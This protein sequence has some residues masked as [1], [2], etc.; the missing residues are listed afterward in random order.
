MMNR[1]HDMIAEQKQIKKERG[2]FYFSM[3]ILFFVL[4]GWNSFFEVL[5]APVVL[6]TFVALQLAA[7]IYWLTALI[8]FK[9]KIKAAI[10]TFFS[11]FF[12]L[13]F[14][15]IQTVAVTLHKNEIHLSEW[16]F[17]L[18]LLSITLAVVFF[19]SKPMP[20][21][22]AFCRALL[23]VLVI[24]ESLSLIVKAV[25]PQQ[26]TD[27]FLTAALA[28]RHTGIYPSVYLIVL[29]EYAGSE[30]LDKYFNYPNNRFL[31]SLDTLGFRVVKNA[32]SNYHYTVLSM[33]SMLNGEYVKLPAERL[34][35]A[36]ESYRES[37]RDIYYN[38]T[39]STFSE[40]QYKLYNYS[41]FPI[42]G[43]PSKYTNRFLP[44]D[45]WLLLHPSVFDRV[46][47]S[48]PY[49]IA[50][51]LGNPQQLERLFKKQVLLNNQILD[52]VLAEAQ[53]KKN[54]PAFCYMHL[55]MPHAPY[56]V[57][58]SGKLNMDFLTRTGGTFQQ[59]KD[60]YLQ[61]LVYANNKVTSF[62]TQLKKQT[63]GN[64]VI[65]LVSD[66]GFRDQLHKNDE[67]SKFNSLAAV[68]L[69]AG[70]SI[71]WYNGMSNVNQ[72]RII[73]SELTGQKLPL[74][75]DSMVLK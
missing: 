33:A 20:K 18:V 16:T 25:S 51:R 8:L 53:Q 55:M 49:F 67:L 64:A 52:E 14:D 48:L 34:T 36:D 15:L 21:L 54:T 6:K 62:I 37:I 39:F 40:L 41:P 74:L 32:G 22:K 13:F 59:K 42:N 7:F 66:H 17:L 43:Y 30:T 38:K 5:P 72:F 69:P 57:D 71:R 27:S 56:A 44:V 19:W 23:I 63:D 2:V 26:K 46:V 60:A 11:F 28:K 12:F 31:Y 61:Y 68:Y 50:R 65:L 29:D 75:K 70:D 35:Y 4:H 1:S 58:S 24:F 9:R 10:F 3:L 45:Y 47:E 73:F